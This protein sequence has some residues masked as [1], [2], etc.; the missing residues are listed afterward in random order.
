MLPKMRYTTAKLSELVHQEQYPLLY[1]R[2]YRKHISSVDK[3]MHKSSNDFIRRDHQ[4]RELKERKE[5]SFSYTSYQ[6]SREIGEGNAILFGKI[7]SSSR[8][9][10][11]YVGQVGESS[12]FE[13]L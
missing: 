5:Q 8:I 10:K 7:Y 12:T 6:R 9:D 2:S 13:L 3:I 4:L 1:R 11:K